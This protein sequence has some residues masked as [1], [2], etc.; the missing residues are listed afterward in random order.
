MADIRFLVGTVSGRTPIS[1]ATMPVLDGPRRQA[2]RRATTGV[3]QRFL[4]PGDRP[5][6][7]VTAGRTDYFRLSAKGGDVL[8]ALG[9]DDI[10]VTDANA[11]MLPDGAVEY[12]AI[13]NA[14]HYAIMDDA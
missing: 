13:G 8:F 9:G 4:I 3:S 2:E 12:G 10:V 1:G 6:G 5:P 7:L 11:T 14:T